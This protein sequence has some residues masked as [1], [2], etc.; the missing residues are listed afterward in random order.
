MLRIISAC[1]MFQLFAVTL[2]AQSD[3]LPRGSHLMPYT[4]Y[5]ASATTVGGGATMLAP[6][7][8][9]KLTQSEASDQ[10]CASLSTSGSFVRWTTTAA[11]Q[12]LVLRFSIPDG[13]TGSLGLYINGT[14]QQ[15][16]SLN[17]RWAWQYFSPNPGDGTKDPTNT[18]QSG[19][20]AR[21]RFDEVRVKLPS[22][23]PVG[24]EIRLQKGGDGITYLVDFI[25]LEP[26]PG[27]V[28]MP[29]NYINVT[30]HGAVP[31]DANDDMTAFQNAIGE[32]RT[33]GRSIYVPAGRFI[34]SRKLDLININNV[35][36]QGAGMWHTEL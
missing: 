26:I 36:I 5:E 11:G 1:M 10:T 16:I 8:D 4:R 7:F 17:S 20:T 22:S 35:T 9:Q 19:W 24:T 21:M 31:N 14:L 12:G 2:L 28:G 29:A 25:E 33:T 23:L 6:T 13:T 27:T 30:S 18:P 15:N 32:A 34:L 3:G